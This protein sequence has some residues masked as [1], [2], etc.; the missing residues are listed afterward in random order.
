MHS[1]VLFVLLAWSGAVQQSMTLPLIEAE[2]LANNPDIRSIV[3]QVRATKT[4]ENTA[5]GVEDPEFMYR[6]WGGRLLQ[7]WNVNQ[8]QHMFMFSQKV[9][10]RGKRELRY[11]IATDE[12][13][14]QAAGVDGRKREV[15][16]MVRRAFY[17]LLRTYDQLRLHHEQVALAEQA[18]S[19]ARIKYT[20]GKVPQQ[21]VFKAQIAYSRLIEHEL[22]FQRE[23]DMARAEL[24]ALMGRPADQPLDV[25]GEFRILSRL[26]SQQ[27][28]LEM[29]IQNRPELRGFALMKNQSGRKIQLAEKAYTPEYTISAGYMIM[30]S[31][32]M[33]RNGFM[34]ELSVSLPWLNRGTHDA[35]IRQTQADVGV[36]D[37]A[38]QKAV[39][40][41]SMEIRQAVIQLES[42]RKTVELYRDTLRPQA[43]STLR[44]TVAA[45]QTDQTDFLNLIDSQ[46]M[47]IEFQHAFF[48]ALETYQ[49]SLADL[50]RAI[51]VS[52]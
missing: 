40:A 44:A 32:S 14:I 24:N 13:E 36:I 1:F 6:A 45:Y 22:V 31:G 35:E 26:P 38:Y 21:D 42:A 49:R 47:A 27:A 37:A 23:A 41:L 20:V 39:A 30:P 7:P 52:L 33:N 9:P 12:T 2:A 28:L 50:E 17:Q 8:I 15:V 3:E 25:V 11:L 48:S 19:A 10:S 43:V 5:L 29:A 18:I 34:A 46:T 16:A 4:R 51:G